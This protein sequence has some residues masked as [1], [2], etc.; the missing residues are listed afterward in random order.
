MHSLRSKKLING[1]WIEVNV[2]LRLC[3][4]CVVRS[5]PGGCARAADTPVTIILRW[6]GGVFYCGGFLDERRGLVGHRKR[7]T[8]LQYALYRGGIGGLLV[9]S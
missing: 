7:R 9:G 4:S 5:S 3:D 8:S 2:V 6:L 1:G